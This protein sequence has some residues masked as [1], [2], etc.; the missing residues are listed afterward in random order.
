MSKK[1][2]LD[3]GYVCTCGEYHLFS[4]WVYAHPDIE[5]V[6]VCDKCGRKNILINCQVIRYVLD[7]KVICL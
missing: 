1:V 5:I 3:R 7:E 2:D 4:V 6:H